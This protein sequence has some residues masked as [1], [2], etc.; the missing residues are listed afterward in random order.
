MT[1][2]SKLLVLVRLLNLTYLVDLPLYVDNVSFGLDNS[3]QSPKNS[4]GKVSV[5]DRLDICSQSYFWRFYCG[6]P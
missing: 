5:F 1:N 6:N 3:F 2:I 4:H